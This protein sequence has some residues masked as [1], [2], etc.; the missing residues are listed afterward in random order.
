MFVDVGN[1][2]SSRSVRCG[3]SVSLLTE[4]DILST[5]IS[6]NISLPNGAVDRDIWIAHGYTIL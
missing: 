5:T 6:T 4:R 1:L 2:T 3:M